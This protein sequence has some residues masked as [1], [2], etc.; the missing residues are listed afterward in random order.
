MILHI[1]V[2]PILRLWCNSCFCQQWRWGTQRLLCA[3]SCPV[4]T[5]YCWGKMACLIELITL[6]SSSC[7]ARYTHIFS[8]RVPEITNHCHTCVCTSF[9]S[10]YLFDSWGF[11]RRHFWGL[12]QWLPPYKFL[13]PTGHKLCAGMKI[14][15]LH[16]RMLSLRN[17]SVWKRAQK[18]LHALD[19]V[20]N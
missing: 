13:M 9:F 10:P 15:F 8:M 3:P 20:K 1:T 2:I 4:H 6:S 7:L 14:T 11:L 5:K 12:A 16:V 18:L 17:S 19:V